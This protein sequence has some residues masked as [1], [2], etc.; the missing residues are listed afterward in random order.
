MSEHFYQQ[1]DK[2]NSEIIEINELCLSNKND[3][4]QLE[5]Y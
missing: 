2:A 1:L 3:V 5:N 4:E